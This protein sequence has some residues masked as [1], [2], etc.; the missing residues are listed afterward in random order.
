MY[1]HTSLSQLRSKGFTCVYFIAAIVIAMISK[2]TLK[3]IRFVM[4]FQA[5]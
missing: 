3:S 4:S 5:L 2:N 1:I